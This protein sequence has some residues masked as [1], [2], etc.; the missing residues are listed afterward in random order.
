MRRRILSAAGLL[1]ILISTSDALPRFAS[2]MGV[3]CQS[4]H[5]NPTGKGMRTPFGQN[6]GAFDLTIPT[7]KDESQLR[8][9]T[10][11]ISPNL[12]IG[13][14]M[15]TLIFASPSAGTSSAFQMQGD[16]YLTFQLN[17]YVKVYADKGLYSGFEIFAL[18]KVLPLDGYVK[19]GKFMPA[20]GTRIDD[21]NAFIRGGP[22]GG[23]L[24]QQDYAPLAAQGYL[25][26][27]R[28][29]E[30]SEDTGLE[31][32][33]TPGV[34]TIT[35]GIFN[36]APGSG[37]N[38]VI[39]TRYKAVA[40]RADATFKTG[41][42]NIMLGGSLY[43]RPAAGT[44]ETFTGLFGAVTIAER[45]TLNSEVDLV[46]LRIGGRDLS[47]RMFWNELNVLLVEGVDLKLGYEFYD[48][49]IDLKNGSF[50]RIVLG[51]EV[52]LLPGVELRPLYVIHKE[53]P[54]DLDN[55]E[56]RLLLHFF[57]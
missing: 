40:L 47:G 39:G 14:D 3:K 33:F 24:F 20:Y 54:T 8:E 10:G 53:E 5:V 23:A 17:K 57:F 48:P 18:A 13:L 6:Y 28:F 51:T 15:R 55:D 32:G 50:T 27:L 25:S 44:R 21:H 4:C 35:A 31:L 22:Y 12:S 29:G 9:I 11:K 49:D 45:F 43:D 36:G 19:A 16:I 7:W 56:F 2:R 42:G 38:G 41:Y 30:R 1:A 34:L 37:L 46:S 26:G 52:F